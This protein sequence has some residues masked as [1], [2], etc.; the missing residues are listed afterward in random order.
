[1]K[2]APGPLATVSERL[3]PKTTRND[4][5]EQSPKGHIKRA[6]DLINERHRGI[7]SAALQVADVGS[8]KPRLI[9][10]GF[11]ADAL[12]LAQFS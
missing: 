4:S 11:L 10:E 9:G 7:A 2:C 12:R 6:S 3:Q 5:V 1:M 8:M